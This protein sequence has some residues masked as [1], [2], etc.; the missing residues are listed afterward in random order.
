MSRPPTP[1]Q[2]QR[3]QGVTQRLGRIGQMRCE[4]IRDQAH[5]LGRDGQS[6]KVGCSHVDRGRL[7]TEMRRGGC[8]NGGEI[9]ADRPL[10]PRIATAVGTRA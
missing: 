9:D 7:T 5:E 1:R 6:G 3:Q 10:W 8:S 2:G 4:Q